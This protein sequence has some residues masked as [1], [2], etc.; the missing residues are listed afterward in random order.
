MPG[1]HGLEP[2]PRTRWKERYD[3]LFTQ[4]VGEQ[5]KHAATQEQL[6]QA[7]ERIKD[8]EMK[9][10]I[11]NIQNEQLR[12]GQHHLPMEEVA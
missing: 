5:K 10:R 6:A 11:Q 8:L 1:V 12:K 7:E 9:I 4:F 3:R 2:L